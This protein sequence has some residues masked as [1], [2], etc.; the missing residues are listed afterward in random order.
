MQYPEKDERTTDSEED[1]GSR[2]KKIRHDPFCNDI[3]EAPND[4]GPDDGK[5]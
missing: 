3:I 1:D 5:V 4:I 2:Q